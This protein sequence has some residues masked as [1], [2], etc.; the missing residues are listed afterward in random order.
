MSSSSSRRRSGRRQVQ[1]TRS[2]GVALVVGGLFVALAVIYVIQRGP[3]SESTPLATTEGNAADRDAGHV[4]RAT[5]RDDDSF[6]PAEDPLE[7]PAETDSI[8][9]DH[10]PP[11][12]PG[13]VATFDPEPAP[14]PIP[15]T[16]PSRPEPRPTA[17]PPQSSPGAEEPGTTPAAPNR[18]CGLELQGDLAGETLPGEDQQTW[19]RLAYALRE[20]AT[21]P[22]Y[23]VFPGGRLPRVVPPKGKTARTPAATEKPRGNPAEPT[24]RISID[25]KVSTGGG[26]SF[27]GKKLGNRYSAV[28]TVTLEKRDSGEWRRIDGLTVRDEHTPGGEGEDQRTT[29]RKLYDVTLEKLAARLV[30][31]PQFRKGS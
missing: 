2:P 10:S 27:Y 28:I 25:A 15:P 14:A 11:P 19:A 31:L 21:V 24:Y 8:P 12:D 29:V 3:G 7:E 4:P 1:P 30:Q 22:H 18:F 20:E 13:I 9:E 16:A 5:P 6:E 26:I 23:I 17:P